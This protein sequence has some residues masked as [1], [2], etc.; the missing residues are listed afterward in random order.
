MLQLI[1]IFK[2]RMN[3]INS[4]RLQPGVNEKNVFGFSQILIPICVEILIRN[5]IVW[6]KARSGSAFYTPPAKAGGY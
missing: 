1:F 2:L 6:A 4:P 5:V 3:E